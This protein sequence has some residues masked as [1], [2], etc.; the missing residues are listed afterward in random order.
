MD[1]KYYDIVMSVSL[2]RYVCLCVALCVH[3]HMSKNM[4]RLHEIFHVTY[5]QGL[6][7]FWRGVEALHIQ[8]LKSMISIA[9]QSCDCACETV[10]IVVFY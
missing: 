4:S 2:C 8:W 1:A 3:L 10:I 9:T 6:N 5:G 7:Y